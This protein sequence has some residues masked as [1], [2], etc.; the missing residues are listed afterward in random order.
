[1]IILS[2]T[3]NLQV[4]LL[5]LI[6]LLIII[7]IIWYFSF[8]FHFWKLFSFPSCISIWCYSAFHAVFFFIKQGEKQLSN[9]I[10]NDEGSS[11]E[12]NT[13]GGG[14]FHASTSFSWATSV[15]LIILLVTFIDSIIM[16]TWKTVIDCRGEKWARWKRGNING[17]NIRTRRYQRTKIAIYSQLSS[18]LRSLFNGNHHFDS[19]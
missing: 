14:G 4:P 8:F 19:G 7:I 11:N 16:M 15:S 18:L 2:N 10:Q 5:P 9:G 13:N 17:I 12:L 3:L 6:P 1:M